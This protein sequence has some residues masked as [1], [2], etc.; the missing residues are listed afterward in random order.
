MRVVW[1]GHGAIL[2]SGGAFNMLFNS[3]KAGNLLVAVPDYET[4]KVR[5]MKGELGS[6]KVRVLF[7]LSAVTAV[8]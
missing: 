1:A 4:T 2:P 3:Q 5:E 8:F 7:P 6:F